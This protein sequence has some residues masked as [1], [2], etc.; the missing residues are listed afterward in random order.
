MECEPDF[1]EKAERIKYI[2]LIFL[3][4]KGTGNF[5]VTK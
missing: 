5:F 3:K 2:G 1:Y 4:E